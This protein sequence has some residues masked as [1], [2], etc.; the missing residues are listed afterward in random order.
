MAPRTAT[1]AEIAQFLPVDPSGVERIS[2]RKETMELAIVEPDPEWP[3]RYRGL[4]E[5]IHRALGD[6]ALIIEHVGSTSVPGLPA[7]DVIDIDLTVAD[8]EDEAAYVPAL[9]AAGFQFLLREPKWYQHRFFVSYLPNQCNLHVWGPG[10]A[11]AARHK[12]FK[13][14][15]IEHDDDRKLYAEAK[16]D[17][18]KA[19]NEAGEDMVAYTDR[20]D[21]VVRDI[22]HRAFKGND[23]ID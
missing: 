1:K 11:E 19:S 9:E 21:D 8:I 15:L 5:R 13:D 23:I 6:T 22:L 10:S 18:A 16:R 20:K 4:E 3:T 17:A 2:H 14:W 12:L 7:K